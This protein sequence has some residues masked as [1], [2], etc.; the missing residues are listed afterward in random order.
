MLAWQPVTNLAEDVGKILSRDF[1]NRLMKL[2]EPV[3]LR[4]L[5]I[6]VRD[7]GHCHDLLQLATA[8]DLRCIS[9]TQLGSTRECETRNALEDG[10]LART[11]IANDD[12]LQAGDFQSQLAVPLT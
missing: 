1:N 11:L 8:S 2:L 5:R 10:A 4:G 3:A 9:G 7:D 12:E 6:I